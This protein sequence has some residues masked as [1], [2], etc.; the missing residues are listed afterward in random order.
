MV[1]GAGMT[2]TRQRQLSLL[3]KAAFEMNKVFRLQRDKVWQWSVGLNNDAKRVF[4]WQTQKD[5]E[6][7]IA[8][9]E[10][11]DPV[12]VARGDYF[13]DGPGET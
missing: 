2:I 10:R 8:R 3:T 11:Y 13:I 7:H 9:Q 4:V 5:A 1:G 12:G 6:Q